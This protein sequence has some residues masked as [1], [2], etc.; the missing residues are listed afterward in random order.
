MTKVRAL[1]FLKDDKSHLQTIVCLVDLLFI[2]VV[3]CVFENKMN[4]GVVF[5]RAYLARRQEHT[6]FEIRIDTQDA[7]FV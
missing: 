4:I 7:Q 3:I 1:F 2:G 6:F 5:L